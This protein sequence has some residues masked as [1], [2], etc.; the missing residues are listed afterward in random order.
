MCSLP[1]A[2]LYLDIFQKIKALGYNCV[3]FYI[4]WAL[5]EGTEGVFRADGI[6]DLDPFFQAAMDAGI[7]LLAR[8]GPC[9]SEDCMIAYAIDV[10]AV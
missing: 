6:F 1:V 9:K 4:D 10:D 7:Y 3:S 8:P 2:G 5:L